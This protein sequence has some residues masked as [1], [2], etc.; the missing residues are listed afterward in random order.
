VPLCGPC[1][2]HVHATS[3]EKELESDYNTVEA[4]A[5][6]PEIRRFVEWISG[7]PHGTVRPSRRAR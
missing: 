7:K 2:R 4:L 3:S 1:H 6:R 5:S